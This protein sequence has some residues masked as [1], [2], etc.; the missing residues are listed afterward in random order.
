MKKFENCGFTS[1]IENENPNQSLSVPTVS[2]IL[3]RPSYF[4]NSPFS[5]SA[6]SSYRL[7]SY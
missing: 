3:I 5:L 7:T 4:T 1:K 2:N 6:I